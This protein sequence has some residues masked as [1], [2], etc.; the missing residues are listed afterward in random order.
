MHGRGTR[1]CKNGEIYEG[2]FE[3]NNPHGEGIL[4]DANGTV[5]H[6]GVWKEGEFQGVRM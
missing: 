6:K 3:N 4:K 2:L 5:I 1:Y